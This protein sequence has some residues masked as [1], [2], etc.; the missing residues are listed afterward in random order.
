MQ[1]LAWLITIILM[2]CIVAV[3]A[4]VVLNSQDATE[5]APVQ[6]RFYSIR[7]K[8]F[9]L[10]FAAFIVLTF[11][12]LRSL[13]YAATHSASSGDAQQVTV[14]GY[15]WYW[16]LSQESVV[17]NQP[18]IFTVKSED[19]NHGMAI[20]DESLTLLTQV[21]SMPGYDNKVEYT[22]T[23]PGTYQI[24]CMEYCGA[25]HHAMLSTL[26]VTEQ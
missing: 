6:K 5:F 8:F 11:I 16:E 13:P 14:T 25:A 1:E 18:V 9:W 23:K 22:F 20:Y 3:F 19:V 17:V 4:F 12:T 7:T 24:L 15:Q 26:Q 10:L 2:L 21:Q